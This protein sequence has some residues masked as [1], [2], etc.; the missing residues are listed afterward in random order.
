MENNSMEQPIIKKAPV[1]D[2]L[3]SLRPGAQFICR[4]DDIEW[5]DE[6][7]TLPSKLEIEKERNRLYEEY[8]KNKYQRD[9]EI[10]YPSVYDQLDMLYHLG[11]EGWKSEINKIKSKYPKPE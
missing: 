10:E 6:N 4:N 11:Y 3:V 7:Q 8:E 2:A 9:R 1:A 5:L